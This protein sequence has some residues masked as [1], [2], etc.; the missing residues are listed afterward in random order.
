VVGV[1]V[2][3]RVSRARRQSLELFVALLASL[4]FRQGCAGFD[5]LL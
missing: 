1:N 2:G 4:F 5:A 3:G